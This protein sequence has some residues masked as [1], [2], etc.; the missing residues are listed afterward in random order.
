MFL[1][2]WTGGS[3]ESVQ[4]WIDSLT[5]A[6]LHGMTERPATPLEIESRAYANIH[7]LPIPG[8]G[9]KVLILVY[10]KSSF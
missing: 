6:D 3:N 2:S 1:G 7:F 9:G 4:Q 8:T 5:E 10:H